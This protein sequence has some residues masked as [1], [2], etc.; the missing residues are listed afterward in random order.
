MIHQSVYEWSSRPPRT[1]TSLARV[2]GIWQMVWYG[3]VLSS[4]T[5]NTQ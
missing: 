1:E 5:E 4:A 2:Y 3:I